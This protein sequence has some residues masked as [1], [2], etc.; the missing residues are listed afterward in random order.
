MPLSFFNSY[1]G[2]EQ[3]DNSLLVA[4]SMIAVSIGL[5][6]FISSGVLEN[7]ANQYREIFIDKLIKHMGINMRLHL[8]ENKLYTSFMFLSLN[9]DNGRLFAVPSPTESVDYENTLRIG[10]NRLKIIL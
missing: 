9:G 4:L 10:Y 5:M 7:Y 6:F 2:K 1:N 8:K 3:Y